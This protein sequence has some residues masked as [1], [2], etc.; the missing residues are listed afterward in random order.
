MRKLQEIEIYFFDSGYITNRPYLNMEPSYLRAIRPAAVCLFSILCLSV[1]FANNTS[2]VLDEAAISKRMQ[3]LKSEVVEPRMDVAVKS[4]LRTYLINNR[5]KAERI[6]GRSVLYFPLFEKHLR[7]Q[8][9][10]QDLKYLAVVESA[11]EPR[12]I[13]RAS[14]MGLWQFM[15]PTAREYGLLV[16][17]LIDE[18][19]DPEKS[20]DAAARHLKDL[21]NRFNDWSLALAAYNSGSGRVSR[22]IKR[23][24]SRNFWAMQRYLPRETRNYVP[25]FIAATYLMHHYEDHGLTPEY[26]DLDLQMTESMMVY[27]ELEF[28]GLSQLTGLPMETIEFLNPLYRRGL[29]PANENGNKL[30]LPRRV[31]PAFRDYL[32]SQRPD[33][34]YNPLVS[35]PISAGRTREDRN[36]NYFKTTYVVQE[37]ETLEK[38]AKANNCSVYQLKAWNSLSSSKILAGQQL[39]IYHPKELLR[40]RAQEV[41]PVA[42]LPIAPVALL[43]APATSVNNLRAKDALQIDQY[44]Q[45][46]VKRRERLRDIAMKTPGVTIGELEHLNQMLGKQMLQPG[47]IIRLRRM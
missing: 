16:S 2:T 6:I 26:P 23:S 18:R 43:P 29:I 19:C 17:P 11:L 25:A 38:I 40:F 12:A 41:K 4:Y 31:M 33:F 8:Q 27:D 13:S 22:A 44:V 32:Q 37:G 24:R 14:A 30:T 20:T 28:E 21:Y 1:V 35:S 42:P 10:P 7:E 47:T 46:V 9:I 15:A 34:R 36:A 5:S 45:Y 39:T 3:A